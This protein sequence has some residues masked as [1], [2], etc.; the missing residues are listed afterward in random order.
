MTYDLWKHTTERLVGREDLLRALTHS[1]NYHGLDAKTNTA[2][3]RLA[4]RLFDE[5]WKH[6]C[7]ET[8]V[9]IIDKMTPE[10]RARIG[11]DDVQNRVEDK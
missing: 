11:M 7:G 5:I 10:E 6:L 3:F 1:I 2:D 8:D 4:G 9:Q